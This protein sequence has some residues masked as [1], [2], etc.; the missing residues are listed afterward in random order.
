MRQKLLFNL[1][2]LTFATYLLFEPTKII[3]GVESVA[4]HQ[5]SEHN[6]KFS[7][8]DSSTTNENSREKTEQSYN[9]NSKTKE[10]VEAS[11]S[12]IDNWMPDKNLQLSVSKT[13]DIPLGEIEIND[14]QKLTTLFARGVSNSEGLQYAKNLRQL[15]I[16]EGS[17]TEIK[18]VEEFQKLEDLNV[19]DNAFTEIDFVSSLPNLRFF[20]A[21]NN[22]INK[23]PNLSNN[24]N[25]SIC[26][27]SGN[28]ISDLSPISTLDHGAYFGLKNQILGNNG[29]VRIG[30]DELPLRIEIPVTW[31]NGEK[32]VPSVIDSQRVTADATSLNFDGY[33]SFNLDF[34]PVEPTMYTLDYNSYINYQIEPNIKNVTVCYMDELGQQLHNPI[35]IS[36]LD[37]A[38]YDVTHNRYQPEIQG[39]YL[40][41]SKLPEN[42]RGFINKD[43]PQTIIYYYKKDFSDIK[44]RNSTIYITDKWSAVDNFKSMC[45]KFG[46]EISFR[47][48][49]NQGGLVHGAV[50]TTVAGINKV[51]YELNG[52][53]RTAIITVKS[54]KTEVNVRNSTI[55]TK[56]LWK[57]DDN[58]ENAY[59]KDGKKVELSELLV[60]QSQLDTKKLENIQLYI[61]MMACRQLH[62]SQ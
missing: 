62:L 19:A 47:D 26:Q 24:S 44:V 43:V 50:N 10:K 55:Y 52:I 60:D 2:V 58:F 1:G 38:S 28:L 36:G 30:V 40:D 32:A 45:N 11:F 25:L 4:L 29:I 46:T 18:Q 48:F 34:S 33:G 37:G 12:P 22:Q 31:I 51:I 17:L 20:T 7:D 6:S 16:V 5:E 21:S 49:I 53:T 13:L 39:Y 23:I 42:V 3:Y 27:L 57:K 9:N 41:E 54:R 59:D 61:V 35:V 15:K 8:A 56:S 14:M